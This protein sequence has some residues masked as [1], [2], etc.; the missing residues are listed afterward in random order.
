M[1]RVE[2]EGH[3]HRGRTFKE[4]V[5]KM[6]IASFDDSINKKNFMFNVKQRIRDIYNICMTSNDFEGFVRQLDTLCLV[7][8][9]TCSDC[10]SNEGGGCTKGHKIEDGKVFC[11]DIRFKRARSR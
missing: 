4:V 1:I 11:P 2:V 8:L 10:I 5:R 6:W 7:K 9:Y 3:I